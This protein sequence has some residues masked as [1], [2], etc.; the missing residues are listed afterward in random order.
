MESDLTQTR[1]KLEEALER[2]KSIQQAVTVDL[3]HVAEVGV[4]AG[5]GCR[6]A[7]LVSS[8]SNTPRRPWCHSGSLS[9]SAS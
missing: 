7:S 4:V 9:S 5:R 3:P 8:G 6:A 1:V 2:V